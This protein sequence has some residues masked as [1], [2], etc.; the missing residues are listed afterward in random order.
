[1]TSLQNTFHSL[2]NSRRVAK[3]DAFEGPAVLTKS[4]ACNISSVIDWHITTLH[5]SFFT[6]RSGL[7]VSLKM[8]WFKLM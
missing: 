5:R 7:L 1:M 6:G 3:V 2:G 4:A 8:H